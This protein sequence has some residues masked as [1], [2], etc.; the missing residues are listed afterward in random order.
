MLF[1]EI[2]FDAPDAEIVVLACAIVVMKLE[3]DLPP[4]YKEFLRFVQSNPRFPKLKFY[5][6]EAQI[7]HKLPTGFPFVSTLSEC[8]HLIM[9]I[10]DLQ[11]RCSLCPRSFRQIVVRRF[12]ECDGWKGIADLIIYPIL[13]SVGNQVRCRQTLRK[14]MAE[15]KA[16][17]GLKG[18]SRKCLDEFMSSRANRDALLGCR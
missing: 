5:E 10:G 13:I 3:G 6:V 8:T 12:I 1:A 17:C 16:V 4:Y 15:L 18:R 9:G 14:V 11:S 2:L 7:L